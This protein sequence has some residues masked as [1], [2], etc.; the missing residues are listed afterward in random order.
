MQILSKSDLTTEKK[1]ALRSRVRLG[2]RLIA[3][4][5]LWITS[6]LCLENST[7]LRQKVSLKRSRCGLQASH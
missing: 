5:H 4:D 6:R 2:A 3:C 7:M 1:G